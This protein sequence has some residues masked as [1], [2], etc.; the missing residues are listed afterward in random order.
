[1]RAAAAFACV[2]AA[3]GEVEAL[4][5]SGKHRAG[6]GG[7]AVPDEQHQRR[8]RAGLGPSFGRRTGRG[9]RCRGAASVRGR[10]EL[11]VGVGEEARRAISPML[12]VTPRPPAAAG[13]TRCAWDTMSSRAV[14]EAQLSAVE[15]I[16]R[17][18]TPGAGRGD[19]SSA[20]AVP[21]WSPG[22]SRWRRRSGRRTAT[23]STGAV[24]CPASA[25]LGDA[26]D[27]RPGA[28]RARRQPHRAHVHRRS[29]GRVAVPGPATG[30]GSPTR[31]I[32]VARDDGLELVGRLHH[33]AGAVRPAGQQAD[34]GR[35]RRLPALARGGG[36]AAPRTSR[37][38]SRSGRSGSGRRP[39]GWDFERIPAFA[40]GAEATL[41][42]RSGPAGL[43][44]RQPAE[45]LHRAA[46]RGDARRRSSLAPPS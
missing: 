11:R 43:L 46:H 17:T 15:A 5:P 7:R 16:D 8:R 45:H 26:A 19:Q 1:M 4:G 3:V 13:D 14:P 10:L 40:H 35:A 32:S 9:R 42:G 28:G 44:P 39:G 21:G 6:G 24:P 38:F 31:P 36:R 18:S 33:R 25:I 41:A 22:G 23:R 34:P 2:R 20:V 29:I 37:S 27:R 12:R 30:P